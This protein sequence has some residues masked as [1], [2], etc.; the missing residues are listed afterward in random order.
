MKK[1]LASLILLF[2]MITSL[3][4][5]EV[6]T[7]K[8]DSNCTTIKCKT[9]KKSDCATP[10]KI[11]DC[12]KCD[13]KTK[14]HCSR[15]GNKTSH[16]GMPTWNAKVDGN[17]SMKPS[18]CSTDKKKEETKEKKPMKCAAGKCGGGKCGGK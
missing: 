5:T 16:K 13:A 17:S 18:H 15:D 9:D 14:K 10:C 4:A 8:N 11:K 12:T 1:T 2:A 3:N 6:A 7:Q